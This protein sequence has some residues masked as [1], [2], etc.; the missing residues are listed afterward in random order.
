MGILI[1]SNDFNNG[2][3]VINNNDNTKQNLKEFISNYE[4]AYIYELLGIELG[5]LFIADLDSITNKPQTQRFIDIYEPIFFKK[6]NKIYQSKGLKEVLKGLVY[7]EFTNSQ[8]YKNTIN[9]NTQSI[10]QVGETGETVSSLRN[11]VIIKYNKSVS[12]FYAIQLY[13]CDNKTVYPEF[14]GVTKDY[15]SSI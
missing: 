1:A 13:I 7:G 3:Y 9:G 8:N 2:E 10:Y 11:G 5:N 4:K 6:Y 15:A 12:S 14:D